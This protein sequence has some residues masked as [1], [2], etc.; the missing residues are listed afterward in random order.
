[1]NTAWSSLENFIAKIYSEIKS[2]KIGFEYNF[3]VWFIHTSRYQ[4]KESGRESWILMS[5]I[6]LSLE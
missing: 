5:Y 3:L 2:K 4:T 1:M 6:Q